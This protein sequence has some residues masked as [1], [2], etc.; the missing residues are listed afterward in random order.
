ML[1]L[2]PQERRRIWEQ[3]FASVEGYVSGVDGL[4]V[5]PELDPIGL[6]ALLEPFDF[7]QPLAPLEAIDFAAR[8]LTRY[9]VHAPHPRY[10]GLFNPAPSTMGI[11]ADT[12]V[13][14]FNPQLAAWSHSPF[15]AEI[16]AHLVRAFGARFGYDPGA[17]D[18][19]FTGGGAEANHTALLTALIGRFPEIDEAGLRAVAGQP[20]FY[21]SSESHHS[22]VK[23]SRAC[24]LG[25]AALHE[26]ACD[27]RFRLD[28]SAL[29]AALVRD[30]QAGLHPF[31]VVATAGT[32]AAGIVDPLRE[33]GDVAAAEGLWYHVDAA[34]GG[35]AALVPEL[36]PLLDGIERADSITFDAHKFL[37]VP[38][39]ASLY[40]TRHRDI[41]GRTFRIETGYMPRDAAALEVVDPYVH[42]MQW[43]RRFIGLKVF[44]TLAV[45]GW[46]GY[47]ATIRRQTAMGD[48]L[49][50]R[51]RESGWDVVND[52]PL[53]VVC[54]Q[55][56]RTPRGRTREFVGQIARRVV[57]SG[58]A[59]ISPARVGPMPVLRACVTN[60]RTGPEHVDAL[61]QELDEARSGL[62][63]S[64][65]GQEG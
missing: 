62:A 32:T 44:L 22:L 50:A 29:S 54:F 58:L 3:V 7:E 28:P 63:A 34:W 10:F 49:R 41:L 47:A 2:G 4:P 53:P 24:G 15:A 37:S 56:L 23:A 45:A 5:A 61:V 35:A 6:R 12:L 39:G 55:D 27:N 52:T 60:F 13:A 30:R 42:S 31:M 8:G 25:T 1:M 20:V 9:Q 59:W 26:V 16:E 46:E 40:L 33:I 48:R 17:V 14:A 64:T 51:L 57:S 38:M 36:R 65:P 18:G 21:T 19:T 43:S 11:A